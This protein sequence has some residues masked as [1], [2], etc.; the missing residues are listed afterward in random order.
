MHLWASVLLSPERNN[1]VAPHIS[2][3]RFEALKRQTTRLMRARPGLTRAMA[4]DE[5]ANRENYPNWSIL[6]K[7]VDTSSEHS[8]PR[9]D[10]RRH[11]I[12]LMARLL[13]APS[14]L[15]A[16]SQW[17]EAVATEHPARRY[18]KFM[19]IP[20]RWVFISP[21]SN[22]LQHK[23]ATAK[24]AIAFMDA[25]G[26]RPSRRQWTIERQFGRAL[27]DHMCTWQDDARR[28][29]VTTEPYIG[30]PEAVPSIAAWCQ[31]HDWHWQVLPAGCGIWNPCLEKCPQGCK[32]HTQMIIL[33][34]AKLGADIQTVKQAWGSP[35]S[36]FDA[37]T[38]GHMLD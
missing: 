20:E 23:L 8:S 2:Q 12:V 15:S 16:V 31:Q 13:R 4:L 10:F 32:R 9:H 1:V 14:G 25:T 36:S 30:A 26:L 3:Q 27:P 17:K 29:L 33:S 11:Q 18:E 6:A 38:M 24:R 7:A 35:R 34:P 21:D 22:D 19:W 37:A 5:I 28:V